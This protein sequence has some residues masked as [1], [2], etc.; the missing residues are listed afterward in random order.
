MKTLTNLALFL[1]AIAST[2]QEDF[3]KYKWRNRILV[4]STTSL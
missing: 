1:F 3:S 4:L 2:A